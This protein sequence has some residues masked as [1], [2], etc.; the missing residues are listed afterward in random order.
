MIPENLQK[1]AN[2]RDAITTEEVAK[3]LSIAPQTI[4]KNFCEQHHLYGIKPIKL[5]HRLL[6]SVLDIAKL[7]NGE[8]NATK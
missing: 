6:W 3:Y 2:G 4:R 5:S 1:L 8:N 7:V